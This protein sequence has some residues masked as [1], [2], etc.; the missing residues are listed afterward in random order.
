MNELDH[1]WKVNDYLNSYTQ[2][3]DL[4][5]GFLVALATLSLGLATGAPTGLPWW[6]TLALALAGIPTLLALLL[7][8]WSVRPRT[9]NHAAKGTIFWENIRAH[10][11]AHDY[12]QAETSCNRSEEV[13]RQNYNIA[14]VVKGKYACVRRATTLLLIGLPLQWLTSAAVHF[15]QTGT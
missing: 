2:F 14:L 7:A 9:R 4:K 6:A 11:C 12:V 3:A 8:L 10:D 13:L 15:L 5:A 1:A